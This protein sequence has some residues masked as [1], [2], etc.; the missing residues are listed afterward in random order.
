MNY[1]VGV[2]GMGNMATAIIKGAIEQGALQCEDVI[3][4]RRNVALLESIEE[5]LGVETTTDN[6]AVV[7]QATYILLAVKPQFMADVI[8]EI[9][10]CITENHVIIT[11]A[12]G[13]T[14]EWYETEFGKKISLIRCMPN[15]PALVGEACTAY[16][17]A[18]GVN[19]EQIAT[20]E[21]MFNAV[22]KVHEIQEKLMDAVVG[23]S[24]S[25]P[26]YVYMM[27]EAMADAAVAAGM[28][29]TQ[30]YE[31]AAQ[32]VYGSA[33]MVLETKKH[34]GELKDMVCSP[35]GTTIQAVE[36]LEKKG[37]RAALMEAMKACIER[38]KAL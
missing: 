34:P 16:C 36:V 14:M 25:S 12:A 8:A 38:S 23:V 9:K 18:D 19:S 15:T 1:K 6:L 24:G 27:I 28:M 11:I 22:G 29:R 32:A 37:F 10:D 7:N 2:I 20:F 31:M 21:S 3:V 13:K 4:A 5:N 17:Y 35:G 33:K 30:A 26:A